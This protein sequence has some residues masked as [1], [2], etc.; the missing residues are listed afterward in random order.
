M[1]SETADKE[2]LQYRTKDKDFD[3]VKMMCVIRTRLFKRYLGH[4]AIMKKE[5]GNA[6]KKFGFSK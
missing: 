6:G 4:P 1:K 5:I 3:C 2:L